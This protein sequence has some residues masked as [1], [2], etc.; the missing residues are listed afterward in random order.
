[1]FSAIIL[2]GL[3]IRFDSMTLPSLPLFKDV[4]L[5]LQ[6]FL[7]VVGT[8]AAARKTSRLPLSEIL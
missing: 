5:I 6:G 7:G 1:M 4:S 2:F 3:I 8:E